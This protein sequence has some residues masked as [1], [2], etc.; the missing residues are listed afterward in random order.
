MGDF[1]M[2]KK[3]WAALTLAAA[4]FFQLT[5]CSAPSQTDAESV[6]EAAT[7]DCSS[8]GASASVSGELPAVGDKLSGFVLKE[9]DTYEP[10][11]ADILYFEHEASGADLYYM[12]NDDTNRA[13]SVAFRTPV[14]DETDTNHIFE[15]AVLASSEKYPGKNVFFDM[16]GRSYNTYVNAFTYN[17]FTVYPVS[18]QSEEQLLKM[19]DVYLSCMEAPGL[20][21]DERF[22][23]REAL[24]YNLYDKKEPITMVGTVFS[25]DM[26]NLTST[27]DEAI[28]NICQV[29]YPGETAAN[30]IGRAHINYEDLTFENMAATYERCYNLDNAI[31]F[32]Y[33]DL[34]YQ[35]FLEFFD[36]EYLS[37]PDGHK[38]D[39][40]PW[41][42]EKTAP[43]YVE[44][45]FYAP[46][47]EGDSTD[48]ASVVYYGFDLDGETWDTFKQYDIFSDLLNNNS[49]PFNKKL[50]E[51]GI[52]ATAFAEMVYFTEKP[53][54][55]FGLQNA[56]EEDAD[57]FKKLVIEVLNEVAG[58]GLDSEMVNATLKAAEIKRFLL[59]ESTSPFI[60]GIMPEVLMKWAA[61]GKTDILADETRA[62]EEVKQDSEQMIIKKLAEK[63]LNV[64]RSALAITVPKPGLA[65]Q[66]IQEQE[67][68]LVKMKASMTDEELDQMIA[69][70]LA[71]DEWNA[72]EDS[73]SDFVIS[74]KSLPDPQMPEG[75]TKMLE[76][77]ITIYNSAA[78]IKKISYNSVYFDSSAVAEEDLHY[79]SL[80][81][82]L[83]HELG[84]E[85]HDLNQINNLKQKYLYGLSFDTKYPDEHAGEYSHPM[86]RASWYG[87]AEEYEESLQLLM[88]MM[89]RPDMDD[90][91]E[92]LRILDRYLPL[93]N[94]ARA[95][96]FELAR[97]LVDAGLYKDAQYG[98]YM[99]GQRFY[100]FA[101]RIREHLATDPSFADILTDKMD[102]VRKQVM[103][104]DNLIIMNV[105]AEEEFDAMNTLSKEILGALPSASTGEAEYELPSYPDR[106]A[107]IIE[108]PVYY[109]YASN[110]TAD[111]EG[112]PGA[113][114]PYVSALSDKY[115][116]PQVRFMGGAYS[117]MTG[118]FGNLSEVYFYSHSDPC[119]AE[120]IDVFEGQA[121][122]MEALALTQEELDGYILSAYGVATMPKG[123]LDA[124]MYAMRCD[125]ENFDQDRWFRLVSE[126]RETKLSDQEAVTAV[127]R[128]LLSGSYLATSGNAQLIQEQSD[129]F[130]VV[131]DYRKPIS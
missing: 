18:S 62:L 84:T 61:T 85:T 51:A 127:F 129:C 4:M 2:K 6:G 30:Q 98:Y 47:Y 11:N 41:D 19:A 76:D 111:V 125:M 75:F 13:F 43:G 32:L 103:T 124:H 122:A 105:A 117:G 46:A 107:V 27:N 92:L 118:F 14:V 91:D 33:G 89:Q 123:R 67:D 20:L 77:G 37:E 114:F 15:H 87:M 72:T 28:R 63:L 49:S 79:L 26:G 8:E 90:S 55:L 104:S 102:A 83:L 25:E 97:F 36:S 68:Y 38:T 53:F 66:I 82:M 12:K 31:L 9:L 80:Y 60:E 78:D 54:F 3:Q 131:Y 35:Y 58:N 99:Q 39:L 59:T 112:L 110:K 42:N 119:V 7:A 69:D 115:T 120:T 65:E 86:V 96:G 81:L 88:E 113:L 52:T 56:N 17:M 64:S 40:R 29:L 94:G 73:N 22:F 44:E 128:D 21:S 95:D 108:S 10:M 106:N 101:V 48:D 34:D 23:K 57:S 100:D 126:M 121:D 1:V 93:L 109:T 130:D 5:A 74:V 71:F 45:L 70:T 24:R 16:M 116:V 50:R